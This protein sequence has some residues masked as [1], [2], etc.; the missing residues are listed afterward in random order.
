MT[1]L[2]NRPVKLRGREIFVCALPAANRYGVRNTVCHVVGTMTGNPFLVSMFFNCIFPEA[3]KDRPLLYFESKEEAA[4]HPG[5]LFNS[6]Y[7]YD[8]EVITG[9]DRFAFSLVHRGGI[10]VEILLHVPGKPAVSLCADSFPGNDG[11]GT[12]NRLEI[13]GFKIV[14]GCRLTAKLKGDVS[15]AGWEVIGQGSPNTRRPGL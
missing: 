1:P 4:I 13:P 11:I 8:M 6:L 9:A 7:P 14:A 2:A 15:Q 12:G 10:S 5:G 3:E